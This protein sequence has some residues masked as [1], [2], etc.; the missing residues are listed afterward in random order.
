MGLDLNRSCTVENFTV[1]D[2]NYNTMGAIIY[3]T[4]T[5]N[6]IKGFIN[7]KI[8]YIG[9][10]LFFVYSHSYSKGI[11][12]CVFSQLFFPFMSFT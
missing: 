10:N 1:L 11:E 6:D 4:Y 12:L 8:R 9:N 5:T 7:G 3:C 2:I